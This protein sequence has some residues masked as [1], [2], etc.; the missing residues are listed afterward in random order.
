MGKPNVAIV[1]CGRLGTAMG[2]HLSGAGYPLAGLSSRSL[3]SIEETA[4]IIGTDKISENPCDITR[5]ADVIFIT[6]PDG[7]IADA[8]KNLAD[9]GG[10]KEGAVV[11]HCSGAHPSTILA[12][13]K[14]SRAVIGSMHPLQSFASKSL[15]GNPFDGIIISVEGG[16]DAVTIARQMAKDLGARCLTIPT[17]AKTLYHA[18]AVV[19]SNYLVTILDLAFRL[20]GTA[21]ISSSDAFSV[22]KP[23]VDGTLSNIEKAG[24]TAALTGPI[25]RG[26]AETVQ[27]H[28][29]AIM[30]K[31]PELAKLYQILGLY[32]VDIAQ[33]GGG[34]E[35]DAVLALRK[36]LE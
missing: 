33:A 20:I 7:I 2:K 4:R 29:A 27:R 17:D 25:A 15:E 35:N 24:T 1:G 6:T 32:T 3:S 36:A 10:I 22:L 11:L 9:R 12:S 23:L 16:D 18:A 14:N 19:A 21:G 13:A 8:C 31:I 26:D 34:I 5:H 30:E 28:M